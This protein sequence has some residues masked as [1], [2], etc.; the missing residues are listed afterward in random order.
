M[1]FCAATISPCG[2]YRYTLARRWGPG[3]GS[4]L[5]I[6]LNPST[7]DADADDPTIRACRAFSERWGK[8]ALE[9]VNLFALRST[10]PRKLTDAEDPVGPENDDHIVQAVERSDLIVAAWGARGNLYGRDDEVSRFLALRSR[11]PRCLGITKAGD[12]RHPLYIA[13]SRTLEWMPIKSG[14]AHG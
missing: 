9:V 6:M 10:D 7:A 13:R 5:W 11:V 12:P 1:S 3:S 2:L 14:R 8:N 4:V